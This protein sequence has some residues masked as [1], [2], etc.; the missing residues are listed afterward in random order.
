MLYDFQGGTDGYRPLGPLVFDSAGNLDG[1]TYYGGNEACD[2]GCGTVFEL[3]PDGQGGWTELSCT[4]S[5]G[6]QTVKLLT[7]GLR[8]T[9]TVTFMGRQVAQPVHQAVEARLSCRPGQA[10]GR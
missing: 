7:A 9:E 4:V 3:S 1:T 2:L 8:L 10:D 5:P 6:A